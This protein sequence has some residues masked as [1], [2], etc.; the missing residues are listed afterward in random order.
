MATS[1]DV[2]LTIVDGGAGAIAVPL[3]T[4]Q[5]VMACSSAGVE[6]VLLATR[7]PATLQTTFG[8]GPLPEAAAMTLAAGGTVLAMKLTTAVAGSVNAGAVL[9]VTAATNATP[10]VITAGTHGLTTGAVVTVAAVGGN[11]AANGTWVVTVLSTTTFSLNGSVGSSAYTSGGTATWTGAMQTGT[12]S[13]ANFFTG[14]AF[15]DLH[16]LVTFTT[17]G[18]VGTTGIQFTV[19]LG[20]G[21]A[22]RPINLTRVSLGTATTYLIPGTNVTLNLTTTKTVVAGDTVRCTTKGPQ[23]N[24][25]G[26]TAGLLA[27]QNSP[28]AASGWGSMHIASTFSGAD[29][30]TTGTNIET[31]AG[32]K[33][34]SRGMGNVRDASPPAAWGGTGETDAAWSTSVLAD[35]STVTTKRFGVAAGHYNMRSLFPNTVAGLPLYRRPLSWAWAARVVQLPSIADHEG[36]VRL[37]ALS[38]ITLDVVNDPID[39]FVY[40]DEAQT[41]PVFDNLTGGPGRI[42]SVTK[43][44]GKAIGYYIVNPLLLAASGSDF[45]LAPRGR[46]MDLA[47]TLV[48]Q[49][50]ADF[51]NQRIKLNRNGTMREGDADDLET[52]I[53]RAID[54]GMAETISGR[55]FVVDRDWNI[56][57]TS[58]VHI[59]GAIQG[60]GFALEIDITLGYGAAAQA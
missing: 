23:P 41:G 3:A 12:G 9:T 57:D 7:Q 1:G 44:K 6:N 33:L 11:T 27:L 18:T 60:D 55:T 38:Q 43:R 54:A 30:G 31:M 20:A 53:Y 26:I 39:G 24:Q 37:G 29:A 32:E 56:A 48:Q 8:F 25:A 58:T 19:S 15:D 2:E 40:H 28:Y 42:T 13:S 16:P 17:G 5:V 21:D 52:A 10:I 34:Y 4:L 22:G 59:T 35:F 45:Q 14:A 50:A 51:V 47:S 46:V 49:T 36:W